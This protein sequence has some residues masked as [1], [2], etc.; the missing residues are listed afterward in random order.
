M[1]SFFSWFGNGL[2][3]APAGLSVFGPDF[4]ML[5]PESVLSGPSDSLFDS[6]FNFPAQDRMVYSHFHSSGRWYTLSFL[7]RM[8][9][10][11]NKAGECFSSPNVIEFT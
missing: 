2:C 6:K 4:D 8:R 11:L 7:N 1:E 5:R 9:V 10:L 3:C